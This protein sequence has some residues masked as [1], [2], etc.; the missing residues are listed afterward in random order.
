MIL[1]GIVVYVSTFKG[2]VGH[3]LRTTSEFQDPMFS[4]RYGYSFLLL[5]PA[6]IFSELTGTL[7]IFLYVSQEHFKIMI[8]AERDEVLKNNILDILIGDHRPKRTIPESPTN[9]VSPVNPV[10]RI[11]CDDDDDEEPGNKSPVN[12]HSSVNH[13]FLSPEFGLEPAL[14]FCGRHG[15]RGRRNSRS[16]DSHLGSPGEP[17]IRRAS[18]TFAEDEPK[19]VEVHELHVPSE[20]QSARTMEQLRP[21]ASTSSGRFSVIDQELTMPFAISM[22]IQRREALQQHKAD[23][24]DPNKSTLV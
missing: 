20:P 3:K 24:G 8:D 1:S 22:C 2:E 15:S 17:A 5:L 21:K 7:A 14:Y 19:K 11:S 10:F 4:Y 9:P 12:P 16:T 6:L 18:S 13:N 23:H